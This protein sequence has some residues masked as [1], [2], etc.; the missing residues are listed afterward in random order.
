VEGQWAVADGWP[1]MN[2]NKRQVRILNRIFDYEEKAPFV[3]SGRSLQGAVEI[4]PKSG[5]AKCHECGH[6]ME[7]IGNHVARAHSMT[8]KGYKIKHGLRAK[9]SLSSTRLH[10]Q[11]KLLSKQLW[12][13]G[14]LA[15]P[16]GNWGRHRW[17]QS[18]EEGNN[19]RGL[20][21]VQMPKKIR[22]LAGKLG[23][24][25]STKEVEKAGIL[26]KILRDRYGSGADGIELCCRDLG[27]KPNRR[28]YSVSAHQNEHLDSVVS[29]VLS[30]GRAP[31]RSD[32]AK[33]VLALSWTSIGNVFGGMRPML[34]KAAQLAPSPAKEILE[35]RCAQLGKGGRTLRPAWKGNGLLPIGWPPLEEK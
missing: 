18:T 15:L 12:L 22:E 33:G 3:P 31:T 19:V 5:F 11:R 2:A 32:F 30:K 29:F 23:H 8:A 28:P 16:P 26:Y 20:C 14:R 24:M 7:S 10:E 4:D 21:P 6:W 34:L 35:R 1:A 9:T 27:L 13:S 17:H 25:P